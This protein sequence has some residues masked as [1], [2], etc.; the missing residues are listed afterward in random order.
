V[1]RGT[2]AVA[3]IGLGAMGSRLARRLAVAQYDVVVRNRSPEK[4]HD[5]ASLGA[6][7]AASPADAARRSG[8][9]ITMVADPAAL[10]AVTEG[11]EYR[12]G[13]RRIATVVEMSTVGRAAVKRLASALN[14]GTARAAG[15]P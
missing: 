8:T 5:L 6:T 12:S 1:K 13:R 2:T 9:V 7:P 14:R 10:R 4:V 11:P 3:V 15:V